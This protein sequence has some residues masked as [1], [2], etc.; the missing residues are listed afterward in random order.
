[1]PER[2]RGNAGSV[3]SYLDTPRP[4]RFAPALAPS[5]ACLVTSLGRRAGYFAPPLRETSAGLQTAARIACFRV[6]V[7]VFRLCGKPWREEDAR[8]GWW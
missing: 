3:S 8:S 4:R 6:F 5:T 2:G 1:M 7:V